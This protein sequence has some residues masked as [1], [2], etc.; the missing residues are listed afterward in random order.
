MVNLYMTLSNN[1]S[2][3]VTYGAGGLSDYMQKVATLPYLTQE[4]EYNFAKRWHIEQDMEAAH[5][6]QFSYSKKDYD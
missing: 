6:L 4:E 2:S 1:F 5:A 3:P